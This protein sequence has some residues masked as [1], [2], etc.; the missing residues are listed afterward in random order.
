MFHKILDLVFPERCIACGSIMKP[1]KSRVAICPHCLETLTFL[2]EVPTCRICGCQLDGPEPFCLTCQT[3]Q[4][5]FTRAVSCFPYKGGVRHAVL[6]YKFGGRRDYC[7]TFSHLLTY[8]V[9]PFHKEFPFDCVVCAPMTKAALAERG[10]H[11]TALMASRVA[12]ALQIPFLA[13]ALVKTKETKKQSTLSGYSERFK[14]VEKAFA[15]SLPKSMFAGKNILLIDDVLTT[16]ATADALAKIQDAAGAKRI[17]VATLAG[18]QK[19][20]YE[21]VTEEDELMVT[22]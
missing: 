21:P 19:E 5:Y 3:H 13:D 15:L 9:L 7:R 18:T 6:Q 17:F 20:L 11:Q 10:Y 8:R 1:A 16:G 14:N 22:Y 2:D 12:D 4:H